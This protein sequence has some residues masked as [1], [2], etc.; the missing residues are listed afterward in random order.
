MKILSV[1]LQRISGNAIV[2]GQMSSGVL[3]RPRERR[4]RSD[5][6]LSSRLT[7]SIGSAA[8]YGGPRARDAGIFASAAGYPFC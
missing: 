3:R 8:L 2:T 5:A 6:P 7:T 1:L 4:A